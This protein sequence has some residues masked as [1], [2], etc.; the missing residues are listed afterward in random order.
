MTLDPGSDSPKA[1]EDAR[2]EGS[3]NNNSLG[4]AGLW[5]TRKSSNSPGG[6]LNALT[7]NLLT[8]HVCV[9]KK[10]P[11]HIGSVYSVS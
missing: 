3:N 5:T 7:T 2:T 10:K 11:I 1:G 6:G 8:P 9:C 4:N